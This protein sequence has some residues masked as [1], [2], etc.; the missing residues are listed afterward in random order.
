MK[1]LKVLITIFVA[2]SVFAQT[3]DPTHY[4]ALPENISVKI[5]LQSVILPAH[6]DAVTI[7]GLGGNDFHMQLDFNR[8]SKQNSISLP[9]NRS[10]S[11]QKTDVNQ[12]FVLTSKHDLNPYIQKNNFASHHSYWRHTEKGRVCLVD[13]NA[14]YSFEIYGCFDVIDR[15]NE[16]IE[17]NATSSIVTVSEKLRDGWGENNSYF[18]DP[19]VSTYLIEIIKR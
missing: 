6:G 1:N 7:L 18:Q 12:S 5:T 16:M 15:A 9:Q 8:V 10:D 17:A 2:T 19:I 11:S 4:R 3:E 14:P 13:N